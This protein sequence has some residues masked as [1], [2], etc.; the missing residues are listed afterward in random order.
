MNLTVR[1]QEMLTE[2]QSLKELVGKLLLKLETLEKRNEFLEQENKLL[3]EESR[4]LKQ[5]LFGK[6][7]E[8][9]DCIQQ[10]DLFCTAS[11][12]APAASPSPVSTQVDAYQRKKR[13][14]RRPLP[15]HIMWQERLY[16][17]PDDQLICACGCQKECIRVDVSK[18]IQII[19]PQLIGIKRLRPIYSCR[20]C[21]EKP[22]SA[23]MPPTLLPKC[24]AGESLLAYIAIAK[25]LDHLPLYRLSAQFER[26][27][28]EI[29]RANMT[30]WMLQLHDR[31]EKIINR[32]KFHLLSCHLIQSDETPFKVKDKKHYAWVYRGENKDDENPY[33][34][35]LF[36]HHPGRSREAL[37]A[38]LSQFDGVLQ[39][40]GYNV[41]RG[42]ALP[43][44]WFKQG[45]FAH[46]RRKF[47]EALKTLPK[48]QQPSHEAFWF[49]QKIRLLY[50]LERQIKS[51][52]N[53]DK[54]RQ[55][56]R[57]AIPILS[58]IYE[59]MFSLIP[60]VPPS[61]L[62]G[63]ALHY[64]NNEWLYLTRYVDFG[65]L[66]IDNNLCEQQIRPFVL[67]RK[68]WLHAQSEKG[69]KA[70]CTFYSLIA[71]AKANG[72]EPMQYLEWLFKELTFL[73]R[74]LDADQMDYL[75]PWNYPL[76]KK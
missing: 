63:K 17:V 43:N 62:F 47:F 44:T 40:D 35:I 4:L 51:L 25:F 29:S 34:L 27:G 33:H 72:V 24:I 56:R 30:N 49:I 74:R 42:N 19:A 41:Y 58:L 59:R 2:I 66:H 22:V 73:P 60:V 28:I 57:Q 9:I 39:S 23:P 11:Q 67:G 5:K 38:L 7:S 53:E 31:L 69:A 37:E 70:N 68:N 55:R 6:K 36:E 1:E 48:D 45:C 64:L 50:Q 76:R 12:P 52:P 18:Q 46:A 21:Q 54:Y 16:D 65:D 71:T 20:H 8:I 10:G 75:M 32:F 3:R 13:G 26:L 14:G 15:E 61:S